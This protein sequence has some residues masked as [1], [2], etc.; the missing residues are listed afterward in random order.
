[1][2]SQLNLPSSIKSSLLTPWYGFTP[3]LN[4]GLH[5]TTTTTVLFISL[6]IKLTPS[7]FDKLLNKLDEDTLCVGSILEGHVPEHEGKITGTNCP[8][9]T[10]NLYSTSKL[11]T[12]RFV[13]HSDLPPN[14]GVEEVLTCRI[15]QSLKGW[16]V[17]MVETGVVWER[18]DEERREWVER[19]MESKRERAGGQ[20]EVVLGGEGG[21]VEVY[22]D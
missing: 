21:R 19:K 16:K 12:T 6:E 15:I 8:W 20:C 22:R 9:N 1:M 13:P 14:A 10:L 11:N 7:I 18:E 4:L 3:A 17:K 5:L 2:I